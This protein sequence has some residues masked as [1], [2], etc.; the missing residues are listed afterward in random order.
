[1]RL[2]RHEEREGEKEERERWGK[3]GVRDE[4]IEGEMRTERGRAEVREE[5]RERLVEG[6]S[7]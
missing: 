7:Y 4:E 5:E 3:A 1:M 2:K 6:K